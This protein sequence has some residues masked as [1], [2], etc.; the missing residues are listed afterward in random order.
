MEQTGKPIQAML[1]IVGG[2][3]AP[4]IHALNEQ[5]PRFI[6]FFV[7]QES[8]SSIRESILPALNY[9]PEHHDW[10][11]TP[12]AQD[13]LECYQALS[14][15][16]PS[17]LDK[18]GVRPEELGVE[19]TAGTKPMSVAAVLA[20]IETCSQYYYVGSKDPQGRDKNGIGVVIDEREFTWFQTNPW[21]QLAIPARKEIALL[22]NHGRFA[23]AQERTLRLARVAS[24]N[25]RRIYEALAELIEAY[26][27][28]DRFEYKPA[29]QRMQKT[30][31]ALRLYVAGSDDPLRITLDEVEKN[32]QFLKNLLSNN[33]ES[34]CLDILD[35]I[36]NATRRAEV[37]QKYDDAAARLYSALESLARYRLLN[38]NI[39]THAVKPEQIPES[40]RDEYI[41]RYQSPNETG[42]TM[43]LGLEA[44]YRL[45]AELNDPL[46]KKY[47]ENEKELNQVL[48][49]RNQSRL[50]HGN[51]PIRPEIYQRMR[52]I[53]MRFADVTEDELPKFPTMR[54]QFG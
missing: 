46:G 32:A 3:T 19:Y 21:E 4:A 13:L 28:W 48:H 25:M 7:S 24:N 2:A 10:I 31:Q 52:E 23:D 6:C 11:I 15:N 27:L 37:A 33:Q 26:A 35:L 45:L 51:T 54:L 43:R 44:S 16:L 1:V 17:I 12:V 8:K 29:E 34:H 40:I 30:L 14:K 41:K 50:A 18:W 9:E 47:L 20:T 5:Q 38:Y 49:T 39:M 22:F 53:V 36:A 42:M